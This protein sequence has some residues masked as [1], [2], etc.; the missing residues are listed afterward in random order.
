MNLDNESY[1][2][3]EGYQHNLKAGV[4]GDSEDGS[5]LYQVAVY[6]FARDLLKDGNLKSVLDLGCGHGQKLKTA[7]LPVCK[8]ITGVDWEHSIDYCKKTYD[9]GNWIIDNIEEPTNAINRKFDLII[10]S[11]VIEHLF[12]PDKLFSYL[13]KIA[14]SKT[15][16]VLSTPERDL[17]RGKETMGPPGNG[18]HIREWNKD[19]LGNYISS[20]NLNMISHEIVELKKDIFTCQMILCQFD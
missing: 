5:K 2:I 6:D 20:M 10:C 11:D 9:F 3:K 19:E 13:R 17:R 18:T 15:L 12:D 14:H 1:F 16:I 8:D 7:I 4:Y